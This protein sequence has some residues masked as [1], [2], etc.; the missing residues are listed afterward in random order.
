[1]LPHVADLYPS[2]ETLPPYYYA[3]KQ[4]EAVQLVWNDSVPSSPCTSAST[5][6]LEDDGI[7]QLFSE[8]DNTLTRGASDAS[9]YS[10]LVPDFQAFVTPLPA[11]DLN[12]HAAPFV[13]KPPPPKSRRLHRPAPS[14]LLQPRISKWLRTFN[15]ATRMPIEENDVQ[16]LIVVAAEAWD[17][18]QLAELAQEFCWRFS[19]ATVDDMEA[20]L[21][22]MVRLYWQFR[23]LKSEEHAST[24]EWHLKESILGTFISVWDADTN[25]EAISY[26]NAKPEVVRA[27]LKLT[28]TIGQL[29]RRGFLET[30]DIHTCLK[31]LMANL[32][33]VEHANAVAAMFHHIGPGYWWQHPDGLGHLQEFQYAFGLVMQKLKGTM[34]LLNHPQTDEE[35][36]TVMNT[37]AKQCVELSEEMAMATE[38]HIQMHMQRPPPPIPTYPE[39][40]VHFVRQEPYFVGQAPSEVGQ[41]YGRRL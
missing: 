41:P 17:S 37:V 9:C 6:N 29:F 19:E 32:V 11:E 5:L 26:T 25:P 8:K 13:P 21:T 23:R 14:G 18:E 16:T 4:R 31:T 1:M 24:F 15:M 39:D 34:S 2:I 35:L 27:A 12:P 33:S 20:I 22:F 40:P 7:R 36:A 28:V 30:K 3:Q 38:A 10:G